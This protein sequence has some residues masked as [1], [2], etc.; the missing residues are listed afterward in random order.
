MKPDERA[1]LL[2][3]ATDVAIEAGR[4][5]LRHYQTA[6]SVETKSDESP[7]TIADRE[8]EQMIRRRIAQAYPH[9]AV[10]GEEFGRHDG[11]AARRWII[12]PI[13]GTRSFIRG[14]PLFG[15]MIAFEFEGDVTAG[16][17]HFPVLNETV[18]AARGLGCTWNGRRAR[19]AA[20]SN[21]RDALVLTTDA[22]TWL[23]RTASR[24]SVGADAPMLRTWGDCY[25]YA[26]VA[27]GR[28][29]CMFDPALSPWDIAAL[30]PI[31]EEAGGVITDMDGNNAWPATSAIA[32]NANL[33]DDLRN[34]IRLPQ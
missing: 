31:I 26:L 16:V 3:F 7:V 13:D 34:A 22:R 25:G 24:A 33:A 23:A 2:E 12:D 20:V 18:A 19:V 21:M 1:G 9:D 6:L 14:V 27:T 28:A 4:S 17:L 29:E 15:V 8:A 11:N 5:I 30:V 32:T 10:S